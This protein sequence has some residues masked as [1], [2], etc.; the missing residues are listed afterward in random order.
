MVVSTVLERN[1]E[2]NFSGTLNLDDVR[3]QA[4][5]RSLHP[6]SQYCKLFFHCSLFAFPQL[7]RSCPHLFCLEKEGGGGGGGGGQLEKRVKVEW[8]GSRQVEGI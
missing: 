5:K 8:V 3:S 6:L 2:V 7:P 1:C 4:H